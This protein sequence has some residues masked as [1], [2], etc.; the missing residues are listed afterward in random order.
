M[1]TSE[2]FFHGYILSVPAK[3]TWIF[4]RKEALGDSFKAALAFIYV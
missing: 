3:H 4:L 1:S 2:S